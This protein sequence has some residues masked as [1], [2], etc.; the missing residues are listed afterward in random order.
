MSRG[1]SLAMSGLATGDYAECVAKQVPEGGFGLEAQDLGR[2]A[3]GFGGRIPE[4]RESGEEVRALWR[5]RLR[6][7]GSALESSDLVLEFENQSLRGLLAHAGDAG[8]ARDVVAS[9]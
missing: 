5:W 8:Q 9:N 3:I 1:S 4:V 6:L 7:R 2:G